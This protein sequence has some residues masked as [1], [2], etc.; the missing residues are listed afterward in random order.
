MAPATPLRGVFA[1]RWE[2]TETDGVRAL[3]PQWLRVG[4]AW[5]WDGVPLRLDGAREVLPLGTSAHQTNLQ[6]RARHMAE[7]ISGQIRPFPPPDE[8]SA[9]PQQGFALT[10]GFHLYRARILR[11]RHGN[12][13]VFEDALPPYGQ[14]CWITAVNLTEISDGKQDEGVICFASDAMI[15][16]EKGAVPIALLAP[17]DKVLTRDNGPQPVLWVGQSTLSGP[18][19]RRH[20]QLRPIRL[21]RGF[22]SAGLP[23]EDLCVSPAHR[24]LVD[25]RR[26]QEHFCCDEVLV[27][28]VDLVD[29]QRIAPDAALHGVTYVHLM[30]EAHQI[31]FANGL[32]TESFH[33]ALAPAATLR[34]HSHALRQVS[35]EIVSA[36]ERYGPTARRCLAAGEAALLAA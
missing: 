12:S 13:V 5:R 10:D 16:T 18:A 7:R 32:P 9:A 33:P 21:R 20:P 8:H 22:A 30:L 36:P 19:L 23:E 28:A 25:G 26:A 27:R 29:Y 6:S 2:D 11:T 1:L 14:P 34:Q 31:I 17:G 3:A 24:L 35:S 4:A 15:A